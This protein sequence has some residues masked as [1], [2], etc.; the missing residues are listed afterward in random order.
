MLGMLGSQRW[1]TVV[2]AGGMG[3]SRLADVVGRRVVDR[4]SQG[5]EP[6]WRDGVWF[7]DLAPLRAD[8]VEVAR[9]VV[10][11]LGLQRH[12]GM[13]ATETV[14]EF[15]CQRKALLISST[16]A[17]TFPTVPA[18]SVPGCWPLRSPST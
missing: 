10:E 4:L 5:L 11:A 12:P 13:S 2:G 14:I 15:L 1:V 8:A 6:R 7:V 17:N 16:I 18:I 9:V 3:K